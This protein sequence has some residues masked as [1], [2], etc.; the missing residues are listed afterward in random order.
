MRICIQKKAFQNHSLPVANHLKGNLYV[1]YIGGI[2][3]MMQIYK[4]YLKYIYEIKIYFEY[5][6]GI[7]KSLY[8]EGFKIV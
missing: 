8:Y 5:S 3:I 1:V 4:M 2:N 6:I 7:K